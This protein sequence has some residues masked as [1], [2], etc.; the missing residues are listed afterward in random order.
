MTILKNGVGENDNS[1]VIDLL[2]G[3]A[4]NKFTM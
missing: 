1:Y 3:A 4:G 2:A